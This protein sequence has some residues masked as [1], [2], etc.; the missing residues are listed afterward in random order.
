MSAAIPSGSLTMSREEW[1][2]ARRKTITATDVAAI[3]GVHPYR[4]PHQVFLDK[5]GLLPETPDNEPMFFGRELEN[6]VGQ[7][8]ALT[9]G[10]DAY[11]ADFVADPDEPH[12]ACTPDFYVVDGTGLVF[13]EGQTPPDGDEVR[14]L[15][16]KV[17]G[18]GAARNF[19]DSETDQVPDHYLCQVMWQMA[20]TRIRKAHLAVLL[21]NLRMKTYTFKWDEKLIQHMRFQARKFRNEYILNECP[22]PI[23]GHK[24]DTEYV[25][26][27][28]PAE[29]PLTEVVAT[30]E[31]D[32]LAEQ[33]KAAIEKENEASLEVD[34]LKNELRLFMGD[35][36]ILK[37]TAG[38]FTWKTPSS[39]YCKWREVAHA[40]ASRY[41]VAAED[42][43]ALQLENTQPGERRF[44]TP[45]RSQRA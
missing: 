19:G 45:F 37:T 28:F 10:M 30:Y 25:K 40:L 36:A 6:A 3:L 26:E 16:C 1:L 44:L 23:T 22:P 14:I 20:C 13:S 18:E 5:R 2:E 15:E 7:R 42:L 31:V 35:A 4:T 32:Q 21:P 34:R 29:V 12:F 17:A 43:R 39:G 11:K 38:N 9:K 33:L 27:R 8:F 24:L 41:D